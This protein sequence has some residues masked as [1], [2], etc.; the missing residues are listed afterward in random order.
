MHFQ[1]DLIRSQSGDLNQDPP[2]TKQL[3]CHLSYHP[4]TVMAKL[5]FLQYDN[6]GKKDPLQRNVMAAIPKRKKGIDLNNLNSDG[7]KVEH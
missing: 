5:T 4:L 3:L 2:G 7:F 6:F 1:S